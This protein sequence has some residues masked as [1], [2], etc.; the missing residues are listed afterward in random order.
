M[1]KRATGIAALAAIVAAYVV[2]RYPLFPLHGMKEF[3]LYL[4]ILGAILIAFSG[5]VKGN[6]IL[7]IAAALGYILGFPAGKLFE[8]S[9]G[10]GLNSMWIIWLICFATAVLLG[11]IVNCLVGRKPTH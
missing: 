10:E 7:P 8:R 9:Y 1:R 3:P 4:C 11:I 6:R 2:F 5:I